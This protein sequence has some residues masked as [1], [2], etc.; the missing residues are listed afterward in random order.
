MQAERKIHA[1]REKNTYI[2][3]GVHACAIMCM[4]EYCITIRH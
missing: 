4:H 3:L 1:G 2:Q